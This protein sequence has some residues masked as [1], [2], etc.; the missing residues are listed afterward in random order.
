MHETK[1]QPVPTPHPIT[2]LHCT[3]TVTE[4][5]HNEAALEERRVSISGVSGQQN[6]WGV[7]RRE[8]GVIL[9]HCLIQTK[10]TAIVDVPHVEP[11]P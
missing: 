1:L 4:K 5:K 10:M 8:R 11:H 6:A 3:W 9:N 2:P 7:E